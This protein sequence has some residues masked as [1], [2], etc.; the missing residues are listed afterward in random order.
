MD[1]AF[2]S[3]ELE[4]GRPYRTW[5]VRRLARALVLGIIVW[6]VGSAVLFPQEYQK[7]ACAELEALGW[8]S[9]ASGLRPLGGGDFDPDHSSPGYQHV[10]ALA[11]RCS[12][13]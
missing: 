3:S 8:D 2:L 12:G 7:M 4:G 9:R 5:L 6:L 1:A 13:S 10:V 11:R